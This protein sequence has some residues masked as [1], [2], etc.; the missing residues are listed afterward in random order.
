MK[1]G[2]QQKYQNDFQNRHDRIFTPSFVHKQEND[3]VLPEID[4][5][6]FV[7]LHRVA[8]RSYLEEGLGET[9]LETL[10]AGL[11]LF[12]EKL[13]VL[14]VV[15]V[16]DLEDIV[17]AGDPELRESSGDRVSLGGIEVED[18]VVAIEKK[19]SVSHDLSVCLYSKLF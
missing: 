3:R 1:P 9:V 17:A 14:Y 4:L 16:V 2:R 6:A 5:I 7:D 8:L 18:R 10:P 11:D 15:S 12:L 19:Y 13:P